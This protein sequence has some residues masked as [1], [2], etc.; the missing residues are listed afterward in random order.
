MKTA[1]VLL[2]VKMRKVKKRET[3][4]EV[5]KAEQMER[6]REMR[7]ERFLTHFV[8]LLWELGWWVGVQRLITAWDK[9]VQER[10]NLIFILLHEGEKWG[11]GQAF[12]GLRPAFYPCPIFV[13]V[14][15]ERDGIEEIPG[16]NHAWLMGAKGWRGEGLLKAEELKSHL[17]L[18]C[19][20]PLHK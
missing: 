1:A 2:G 5:E 19:V 8:G 20:V 13:F 18:A 3:E 11:E 16:E 15:Q 14:S 10:P 4:E 9:M 17:E 6:E 7:E 12:L